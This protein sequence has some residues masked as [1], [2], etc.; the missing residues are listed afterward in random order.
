MVR[1]CDAGG[2]LGQR[3]KSL[4]PAL[5]RAL[6]HSGNSTHKKPEQ[7]GWRGPLK[8]CF[9]HRVIDVVWQESGAW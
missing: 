3:A 1:D 9:S 6:A 4:D 2:S 5:Q 8:L 7:E